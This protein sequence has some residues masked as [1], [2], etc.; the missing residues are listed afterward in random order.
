M[1]RAIAAGSRALPR[2][3]T[4]PAPACRA[5]AHGEPTGSALPIV[6]G[7]NVTRAA[8]SQSMRSGE[9]PAGS[10]ETGPVTRLSCFCTPET[11]APHS[12]FVDLSTKPLTRPSAERVTRQASFSKNR[13]SRERDGAR[14]ARP[15]DHA[16]AGVATVAAAG[17]TRKSDGS[18][19]AAPARSA[20]R[21]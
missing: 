10:D 14:T 9:V 3:A 21:R 6:I 12:S 13:S 4:R 5:G 18:A 17:N 16:V 2:L 1:T 8:L 20:L 19:T 11:A 7:V 15:I